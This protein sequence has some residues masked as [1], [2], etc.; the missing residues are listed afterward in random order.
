MVC[1]LSFYVVSVQSYE[2]CKFSQFLENLKFS[3]LNNFV[4][5]TGMEINLG[6]IDAS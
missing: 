3:N 2:H 6:A 4:V 1:H 5:L